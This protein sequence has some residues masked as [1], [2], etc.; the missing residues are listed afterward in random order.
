[1]KST[2]ANKLN[3]DRAAKKKKKHNKKRHVLFQ[4]VDLYSLLNALTIY[5]G[6]S[7]IS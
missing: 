5:Y 1:M 2:V 4:L 7:Q 6:Q 3:V